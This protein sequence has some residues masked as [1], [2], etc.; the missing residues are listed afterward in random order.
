MSASSLP[1]LLVVAHDPDLRD[2]Y[3]SLFEHDG[4]AVA[5]VAKPDP[6]LAWVRAYQP[7]A[8]VVD[9]SSE[10]QA[11]PSVDYVRRLRDDRTTV[12]LPVV[13]CTSACE[14]AE[15]RRELIALMGATLLSTPFDL[16]ELLSALPQ[17]SPRPPAGRPNGRHIG[18]H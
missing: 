5:A 13:F 4:W 12:D 8:V 9:V 10:A 16:E 15:S 7:S 18:G 11:E 2:F 3:R 6:T 17:P 1:L 14:V